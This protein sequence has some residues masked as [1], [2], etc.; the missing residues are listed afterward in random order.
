MS[1]PPQSPTDQADGLPEVVEELLAAAHHL[2]G[3]GLSPGT[4]GNVSVRVA[5]DEADGD[6]GER[7]WMSA[8]GVSLASL[9][10]ADLVQLVPDPAAPDGY[11]PLP[12][13]RPTKEAG[14]H[15][16]MYARDPRARCVVHLHSPRAV[17]VSCLE[18]WS[19]WTALPP[20]TPYL[21]MRVGSVP[22][23]SYAPP[24]DADQARAVREDDRAFAAVLLANHGPLVAG[25]AVAQA[26]DRAVEVE[27]ASTVQLLLGDR[28]GVR[29]L[30]PGSARELAHRYEQHWGPAGG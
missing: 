22:L 12:G 6:G 5:A 24:G 28:P 4:S 8:S 17:A 26:V 20:L 7:V 14:L 3:L 2:A 1:A 19:D 21:V 10:G 13:P 25:G 27:E 15:L 11:A 9:T 23:I 30:P 18:P 16:A 29:L